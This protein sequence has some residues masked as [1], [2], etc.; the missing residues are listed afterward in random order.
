MEKKSSHILNASSN[1]LGFSL[2]IITSLKISKISHSTHLDEFA[3][4]ACIFFAFSCFFSFL[5]IRAKS[6]ERRNRF[7]DIADYSFLIALF[8]IVL[9]VI[10]VTMNII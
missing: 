4:I 6:E 10:I 1:L 2:V 7:E 8:C 5:S 9:A 3:G